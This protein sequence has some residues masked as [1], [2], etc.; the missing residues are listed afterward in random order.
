MFLADAAAVVATLLATAFLLPQ[1]RK[2]ARTGDPAGVS[3]TWAALGTVSNAGWFGYM[4]AKRLWVAAPSAV[5]ILVFYALTLVYLRRAGTNLRGPL[6]RGALWATLLTGALAYGGWDLLGV[7]LGVSFGIQMTPSVWTAYREHR[8]SG[9]S[10]GTWWIGI[11][12]AALW[13]FYGIAHA[14]VPLTMF[15]GVYFLGSVVMLA[16]YYTTRRRFSLAST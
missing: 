5:P 16:R 3:G 6:W 12:E 15:G 8:P 2:L 7:I 9:I 1:L 14:D 13:W 10:P 4:V 11:A